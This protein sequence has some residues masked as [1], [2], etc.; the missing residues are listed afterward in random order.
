[1]N[2]D[3]ADEMA[4]LMQSSIELLR[5]VLADASNDTTITDP[6]SK[7]A[8]TNA[9]S[10]ISFASTYTQLVADNIGASVEG[11]IVL[12]Y[13]GNMNRYVC[14]ECYND[15]DIVLGWSERTCQPCARECTLNELN[16]DSEWAKILR[17][18]MGETGWD[19]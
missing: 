15:G 10:T 14:F 4:R 16:H 19:T 17:F 6:P 18:L 3:Y 5:G 9:I 11:G 1:M 12:Y 8:I 13:M 7:V 2:E